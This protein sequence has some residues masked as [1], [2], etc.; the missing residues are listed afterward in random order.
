MKVHQWVAL[1]L[2]LLILQSSMVLAS[3]ND[4]R[5]M[6]MHIVAS[7]AGIGIGTGFVVAP[8]FVVTNWHVAEPAKQFGMAV[9]RAG[10]PLERALPASLHWHSEDLDLAILKVDQLNLSG[11]PL[12]TKTP[13]VGKR[14]YALGYPGIVE[15]I[16]GIVLHPVQTSG[17]ISHL[18]HYTW[19]SLAETQGSAELLVLFHDADIHGGNSGG[20]LMN[21]CGEVIGVNTERL[22]FRVTSGN[23]EKDEFV[24]LAQGPGYASHISELIPY[25]DQLNISY[26]STNRSCST[27]K[28]GV[29]VILYLVL[30]IALVLAAIA[31]IV[32]FRRPQAIQKV[33]QETY[34]QWIR[35]TPKQPPLQK[36]REEKLSGAPILNWEEGQNR[37]HIILAPSKLDSA[38]GLTL[39]RDSAVSHCQI[40]ADSVSRRHFAL[41]QSNKKLEICDLNSSNGT[42]L[43]G[44]KLEP[45][46]WQSIQLGEQIDL[47][48]VK[49]SVEIRH[50]N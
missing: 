14:V 47:G 38:N 49:C 20:P 30:F 43:N 41:R 10:E 25:L 19:S 22:Q 44:K 1:S 16:R 45:F 33:V 9:R 48:S 31:L 32:A 5:Q 6:V 2:T 26:R 24:L 37:G 7:E 4:A 28:A 21:A 13:E 50:P 11:L 23:L 35:R 27:D 29:P 8:G 39:G 36:E 18:G 12:N 40:V 46:Q 17:S 3:Q 42:W 34:T 15:V